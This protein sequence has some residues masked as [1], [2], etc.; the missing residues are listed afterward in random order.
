M[1]VQ[2]W[3]LFRVSLFL[4]RLIFARAYA[5]IRYMLESNLMLTFIST[6]EFDHALTAACQLKEE[7]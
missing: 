6:D 3:P 5:E 2:F 4:F 1:Y 7:W